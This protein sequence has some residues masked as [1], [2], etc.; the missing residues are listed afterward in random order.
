[1]RTV[2]TE[3]GGVLVV[4]GVAFNAKTIQYLVVADKVGDSQT[5]I[6]AAYGTV[7]GVAAVVVE[8]HVVVRVGYCTVDER[9]GS[10]HKGEVGTGTI[11]V[12]VEVGNRLITIDSV[13]ETETEEV[14]LAAKT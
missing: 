5:H 10:G 11:V 3:C 7:F 1:M 12:P 6:E 4:G 2:D 13:I 14:Y 9:R 8:A